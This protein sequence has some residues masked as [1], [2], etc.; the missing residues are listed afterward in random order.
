MLRLKY[1]INNS[2]LFLFITL[3]FVVLLILFRKIN[4]IIKNLFVLFWKNMLKFVKYQ[5][6]MGV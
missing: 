1:Y 2:N 4:K 3:I 6:L 5:T